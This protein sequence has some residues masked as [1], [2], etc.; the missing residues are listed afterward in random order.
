M[1]ALRTAAIAAAALLLVGLLCVGVYLGYW[2]LARDTTDRSVNVTNRNTGTQTAWRDEAIDLINE[3]E[4]LP[5]GS[6]QAANLRRQACDRIGRLTT[7][8][9]Q[10]DRIIEAE[11]TYC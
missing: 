8:Y 4:L 2:W 3:A 9:R 7:D 10:D 5:E 1:Q 11:E 6:P